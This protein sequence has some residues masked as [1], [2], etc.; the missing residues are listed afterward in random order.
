MF[1]LHPPSPLAQD[2]EEGLLWQ[3]NPF[4]TTQKGRVQED[5]CMI[6]VEDNQCLQQEKIQSRKL[7]A[8]HLQKSQDDLAEKECQFIAAQ[9]AAAEWKRQAEFEEAESK[10]KAE[11]LQDMRSD[12]QRQIDEQNRQTEA[13]KHLDRDEHPMCS[14]TSSV[15]VNFDTK[16][17]NMKT[18]LEKNFSNMITNM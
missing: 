18:E 10:R 15:S 4:V 1:R 7:E 12:L 6:T 5:S 11:E 2:A 14:R 3:N 17:D 16:F 9:N 13:K 8:E